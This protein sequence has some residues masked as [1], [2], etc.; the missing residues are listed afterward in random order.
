MVV[1]FTS[2]PKLRDFSAPEPARRLAS[3]EMEEEIIGGILL[4]PLILQEVGDLQP[5]AFTTRT[6]RLIYASILEVSKNGLKPD[7]HTLASFM[8]R[9]GTLTDIGGKLRLGQL[10]ERVIHSGNVEQYS[11]LLQEDY[12]KQCLSAKLRK[13]AEASEGEGSLKPIV[14]QTRECLAE[15]EGNSVSASTELSLEQAAEKAKSILLANHPELNENILLEKLRSSTGMGS[16]DWQHQIIKPLKRDLD[17]ER[18]KLELLNL[19][20]IADPIEQ[21]RQQAMLA[22]RY[23][24]A[25]SVVEKALQLVLQRT[26]TPATQT[27][28]LDDFFSI[29]S[30]GLEWVIPGLLPAGETVI[31]AGA[32]KSGKTLLTLD[33]AFSVATGESNF[34][35]DVTKRGRVLIISTDE[36]PDS[37]RTKLLKRGF[38]RSD[39]D[40]VQIMLGF[41]ISHIALLEERLESFKPTLVIVDSLKR[42]THNQAISENSAEF[43]DNIYTLKEL[44]TRYGAAALLVHHTSKNQEALGVGKLRG[45]SAIAGAVWGTWLLEQ[46]P[47]P[48]SNNKKKLIIDPKDPNRIFSIFARDVEG[49]QLHIELDLE[50]NSWSNHGEV[51][52]SPETQK[53]QRTLRSRIIEVL[54]RNSH[55]PGL[56]GREIIDLMSMTRS[57]GRSVYSE[58][59]RMVTKRL[60]TSNPAPGDKRFNIYSLP[61]NQSPPPPPEPPEPKPEPPKDSD[62]NATTNSNSEPIQNISLTTPPPSPPP[63]G[64][65][66]NQSTEN[67]TQQ[68]IPVVSQIVSNQLADSDQVVGSPTP[69][70]RLNI[71]TVT[72]TEV[73]SNSD[74]KTG[75][76]IKSPI[77]ATLVAPAVPDIDVQVGD[78]VIDSWGH[79]SRVSKLASGGWLLEDGTH[80]GRDDLRLGVYSKVA[81]SHS[82]TLELVAEQLDLDVPSDDWNGAE[83]IETL[84]EW[85]AGCESLED[86][87][88]IISL[89]PYPSV[90]KTACQS[91]DDVKA[92]QVKKWMLELNEIAVRFN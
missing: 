60:L 63:C 49:Q 62:G 69:A 87:I 28:S 82:N 92:E 17:A 44:F 18:F 91:L 71:D 70:N 9:N 67:S 74:A 78:C 50:N 20:A 35:K 41:S 39:S 8:T 66:A 61:S 46:I 75:G 45:S 51:G 56:T 16:Y 79:I 34:L 68:A 32:P 40:N 14:E 59:N 89:C 37:T 57:E 54:K 72:V 42:I 1:H 85:L 77:P 31:V 47:K 22:P 6:H 76:A 29:Q 19:A 24:M 38:R 83:N 64:S 36:S 90:L 80:I 10:M 15:L 5:A 84:V 88:A 53:E 21:I 27:F 65:I 11:R 12:R 2:E 26:T 55:L 23:Q 30:K 7:G 58:L 4:D 13:L 86:M 81:S 25:S 52:S 73:F 43:A 3:V 33:A 48:D